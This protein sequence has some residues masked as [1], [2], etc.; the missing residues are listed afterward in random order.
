MRNLKVTTTILAMAFL[1]FT[2]SCNEN[3]KEASNHDLH[4]EMLDNGT[5]LN[6]ESQIEINY[7]EISTPNDEGSSNVQNTQMGQVLSDYMTLKDA[8]VATNKDDAAKAG[9]NLEYR[10]NGFNISSYSAEQQ[11][12]L[13]DIISDAKE[14]A[15]HISKSEIDHQREHF[16][17]LSNNIIDMVGITGTETKLFQQFCPMYDKGSS[18]LSMSKDIKNPYYGS[19]MLACGRIEK[20]FN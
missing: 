8:L 2:A 6:S 14:Q 11:K 13:S 17:A 9:K 20:E 12:E 7:N 5:S 18:W 15:E 3:K 16:K 1:A 10:L 4:S 19:K